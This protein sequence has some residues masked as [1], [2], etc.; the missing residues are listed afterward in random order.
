LATSLDLGTVTVPHSSGAAAQQKLLIVNVGGQDLT[1]HDAHFEAGG[2][3]AFSLAPQVP[4]DTVLAPGQTFSFTVNFDPTTSGE[5]AARL[6]IDNDGSMPAYT[7]DLKG[8]GLSL[9]ANL[10]VDVPNN[11]VG[12]QRLGGAPKAL[13]NF[14]TLRNIGSK[15]LSITSIVPD[16]ASIGQFTPTGLPSGFGPGQPLVLQPGDSFT[17]G[18]A[19][20]PELIGLQRGQLR[21]SSNDPNQPVFTLHVIGT[22]MAD[23]GS[24]LDYSNDYVAVEEP[25]NPVA[26]VFRQV[27]DAKGNWSFFLAPLTPIHYTIFDPVS[28]L[29]A[30]GFDTTAPSGQTTT[31]SPPV[32]AAS[33]AP[34]S[35]GDG[36]PDDV[37]FAIGISPTSSDPQDFVKVQEG[38]NPLA[39]G[40][41]PTGVIASLNLS[42]VPSKVAIEGNTAYVATSAGLA[43]VDTT[44][45]TQPQLLSQ[46]ALPGASDVAVDPKLALAAVATGSALAVLDVTDPSLPV[47]RKTIDVKADHLVIVDGIAYAATASELHAIDLFTGE[48]LQKLVLPGA[49]AIT[50]LAREGT[51]VYALDAGSAADPGDTLF[52]IDVSREGS[53]AVIGQLRDPALQG[54]AHIVA[55]NGVVYLSA[56]PPDLGA[57]TAGFATVDVTYPTKP[58]PLASPLT[59]PQAPFDGRGGLAVDGGGRAVVGGIATGAV[60]AGVAVFNVTD[61]R[62]TGRLLF[63]I[64]TAGAP[65]DLAVGT[66]MAFVAESNTASAGGN[67]AFDVVNLSTAA[68]NH[69]APTITLSTS[70]VDLDPNTPGLQVAEGTPIPVRADITSDGPVRDVLLLL[71]GRPVQDLTLAP[72]DTLS[73]SPDIA[74]DGTSITLV[75]RVTDQAGFSTLSSPILV[76]LLP[77][78]V[79]PAIVGIDPA[80]GTKVPEGPEG[81]RILVSESLAPATVT[82]QTFELQDASGNILP[83]RNIQLRGQQ[84]AVQLAYDPLPPG[85]YRL[86]IKAALVTNVAGTP[87]GASDIV[88]RFTVAG[89]PSAA[90]LFPEQRFQPGIN[91]PYLVSSATGLPLVVAADLNGDGRADLAA[92]SQGD[93]SVWVLL[94]KG[95]GSFAKPAILPLNLPAGSVPLKINVID[96]NGDGHPDIVSFWQVMASGPPTVV[97]ATLFGHG[98]G[99]FGSPVEQTIPNIDPSSEASRLAVGDVT[100]DGRPDLVIASIFLTVWPGKGDGTFGAP[101]QAGSGGGGGMTA[102]ADV[103]GDGKPDIVTAESTENSTTFVSVYL[104]NGDGTFSPGPRSTVLG[105]IQSMSVVDLAG[106]GRLSIVAAF[107]SPELNW[108]I[109]VLP[110]DADGTLGARQDVLV[111]GQAEFD[112]V[113]AVGDVTGDGRLDILVSRAATASFGT[114]IVVLV[115]NH[116][117][118]FSAHGNFDLPLIAGVGGV[119]ADGYY[120]LADLTGHG[121]LD[122]VALDS[123]TGTGFVL[124][125]DGMGNFAHQVD[126]PMSTSSGPSLASLGGDLARELRLDRAF[127]LADLNGDG[128]LDIIAG[129]SGGQLAFG[130]DARITVQ[131]GNGDGTFRPGPDIPLEHSDT[132]DQGSG[133]LLAD[134]NG[135]GKLDLITPTQ[136]NAN[137]PQKI[138]GGISIQLGK[139]DGTFGPRTDLFADF[140]QPIDVAPLAVADVNGDGHPD[141]IA[142]AA[143]PGGENAGLLILFGN[144]DGTFFLKP[145]SLLAT[146][147]TVLKPDLSGATGPF[148]GFAV[149]DVNG[150]GIPDLA[151]LDLLPDGTPVASVVLGDRRLADPQRTVKRIDIPLPPSRAVRFLRAG[152]VDGDGHPDL[153]VVEDLPDAQGDLIGI[154]V[155]KGNGD[156]TFAPPVTSDFRRNRGRG[157]AISDVALGDVNGDGHLDIVLA[158]DGFNNATILLGNGDGTFAAPVDYVVGVQP[159]AIRLGDL[160]QNG[161]LD[162]VTAGQSYLGVFAS[163]RLSR[164]FLVRGYREQGEK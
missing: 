32:F 95:D 12:G 161:A 19:F 137:D 86:V 154:R 144:G 71:N 128:H 57:A 104:A 106:D 80:D 16:D 105:E 125:G 4:N 142:V 99:T 118:T 159:M 6:I 24:A 49:G 62:N 148:G 116:D 2:S 120:A 1:I 82:A 70:A 34:D 133:F 36:L 164:L 15:P 40:P 55:S 155:F 114:N 162:L 9:D 98:D 139:G 68:P 61:P 73:V 109:A 135:D 89:P 45:P 8:V 145:G 64:P 33:T 123:S 83:V 30:Q 10:Q 138:R 50:G 121:R 81:I 108:V 113:A 147:I 85:S 152:D 48:E 96:V 94:S 69:K 151:F 84:Q 97:A 37:K 129:S 20:G 75:A 44:L 103:N 72:F 3:T 21:I 65:S 150:D 131:L 110:L 17:L 23:T 107:Q 160:D 53:A 41:L 130:P 143:N 74:T 51:F 58:V 43:I 88:S 100:G 22:G 93:E 163:P 7:I 25:F 14:V 127:T 149:A 59:S 102:I 35:S 156:G 117:G 157:A 31:L 136:F 92:A 63:L 18:L 38:F 76:G 46:T 115:Q 146:P 11:N 158:D 47:V 140:P 79:L 126:L 122:L 42:G 56:G 134:L 87:L 132:V 54:F 27:S 78:K 77:V 5:H 52:V 28:G 101:V 124:T 67:G 112:H 119:S 39:G 111:G 141:I 90:T 66:G 13:G 29:I 60:L 26:P 153:V 91:S